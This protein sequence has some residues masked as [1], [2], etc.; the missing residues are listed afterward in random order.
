MEWFSAKAL[1]G[2]DGMPASKR[3]LHLKAQREGWK[4]REVQTKGGV[5]IEYHIDSLPPGVRQQ[6][7]TSADR[8]AIGSKIAIAA[9]VKTKAEKIAAENGARKLASLHGSAQTRAD[10]KIN[11]LNAFNTFARAS[12]LKLTPA[13]EAFVIAYNSRVVDVD[14]QTYRSFPQINV[15]TLNRWRSKSKRDGVAALAGSYGNRKA[16]GLIDKNR[17]IQNFILGLLVE[18]PHVSAAVIMKALNTRYADH[19]RPSKR[20][21]ERWLVAWKAENAQLFT[22][23]TNPDA[24]KSRFMVAMGSASEYVERLNQLWELD[25]TPAD[26]MLKDGRHSII[27]VVDV[28]PRRAKLLVSKTSKASAIASLLRRTLIDWGVPETAKTDNGKDYTSKHVTRVFAGLNVVQELC[29]PF[30][31]WKKP[32]IERFFRTFSHDL[33]EML[34]GFI[35][36]NVAERSAI[37][38]RRAFSDR[39]LQKDQVLDVALT[40]DELQAFCD[41][42]ITNV[43]EQ[44][45]HA[46]LGGKTPF[47]MVTGWTQPVYRINDER[48]LDILLAEAPGGDGFRTVGKK[49]ISVDRYNYIAADLER[50]VGQRVRVLY[51]PE[52]M[53]RVYVFGGPELDFICIA[54][55]PEITGISR[56]EVAAVAREKQKTRIQNARRE[57]KA[58]AKGVNTRDVVNEILDAKE[59]ATNKVAA[60]PKP[61]TEYTSPGLQS[62]SRAVSAETDTPKHVISAEEFARARKALQEE[63]QTPV[64]PVFNTPFERA[65]WLETQRRERQLSGEEKEYLDRYRRE[66]LRSAKDLDDLLEA[67]FGSSTT[68]DSRA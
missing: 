20:A 19:K 57:L 66:N 13:T 64:A 48:S 12:G 43:Y 30:Q 41:R 24:W 34:A 4:S 35:G 61:A 33:V 5:S 68:M 7:A 11:I 23:V 32:H 44:Q 50:Y 38:N 42:W 36:H 63:Q 15:R 18:N 67:R 40:S 62:A 16:S 54:E 51:D 47:E 6:L 27:G 31:P 21:L 8:S 53:G 26:V 10:I 14:E 46:G 65:Y 22:A 29:P 3:G 45:A 52:D 1:I 25:S 60:F 55:C 37:E 59:A 2:L 9:Q 28:Y 39:L 17:D 58:A 56:Q 49:G